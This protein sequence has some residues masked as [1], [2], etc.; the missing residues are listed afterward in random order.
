MMGARRPG[1]E[2][3]PPAG[4]RIPATAAWAVGLLALALIAVSALL[5]TGDLIGTLLA[6]LPGPYGR[7]GLG[8]T[9]GYLLASVVLIALAG[10]AAARPRFSGLLLPLLIVGLA[11]GVRA[12]F[13]VVADAPLHGENAI[14]RE[15]A[16]GVL[17]GACCFSHRPLGYPIMLAGAYAVLGQGPGTIEALNIVFAAVTAWLTWDIGRVSWGRRVAAVAATAYAVAPSQVLMALVP[18]TEPMY[19]MLV[20]G[21]IRVGIALGRRSMLAAGLACA[22]FLAAGQYVRATA[23]SLLIPIALLPWL[24]GW[25]IRRVL[26]QGALIGGL[27]VVLLLP[28]VAYNLGTHGELSLSTSAYGGWSLY[29]GANREH[30]GQWNAADAAR[31]EGFPGDSWWDRSE[32]AGS[33]ALDRVLENPA[34]SLALLPTKFGTL[35]SSETYAASYALRAG[36]I[37]RD[38]QVGWLA[39]QLFWAPLAVLAAVGM[40]GDR[41][42][43]RP[44]ALLIGMTITLVAVTHLALEVHSRYHAYLVPLFCLLAALGVRT[45]DRWWRARRSRLTAG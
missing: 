8:V 11:I 24:V 38:V 43:P 21:A 32:Y 1:D 19:T 10:H 16:L 17:D 6:D 5:R 23:V 45:L 15:Q 33:L 18:L 36:P 4:S 20:A 39:S 27:L 25:P 26:L 13:A 42:E 29:V 7:L 28:A 34:G 37:T 2:A 12:V 3:T 40:Y 31:L 14:V 30:G 9:A 22:V 41:R 44:A 35:W